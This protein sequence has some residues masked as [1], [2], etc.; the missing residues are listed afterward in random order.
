MRS[1]WNVLPKAVTT[2]I[3]VRVGGIID[4][5][6]APNGDHAEIASTVTGSTGRVFVKAAG[7][8]FSVRSLRYELAATLA[9]DGHPP[10]VLWHFE[11]DGWLVVG[12]EHLAGPHP[13]LSPGGADLDLLAVALK[14]LQE[15]PAPGGRWFT[16]EARL[17]F[18]HP[19]MDGGMLIHSDLNPANLIKTARGLRIVD[20]AWASKAAPWVELALLVQWLIGSGHTPEQAE[21]WLAQFPAWTNVDR[22]VVD[23][24]ASRNATKWSAKSRGTAERWVHDLAAWAG[25]WVAHRHG[26]RR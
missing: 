3:A 23:H 4:V 8:E 17:G 20:W 25:E 15:T 2:E 14:G 21:E 6:A 7:G 22:E 12:V 1:D 26:S 11:C 16:P 24:F 5:H 13:D 10:V 9:I 18:V 19:A